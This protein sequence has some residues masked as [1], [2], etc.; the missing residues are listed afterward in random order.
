MFSFPSALS[1][2]FQVLDDD[3]Q[4]PGAGSSRVVLLPEAPT[5]SSVISIEV[6]SSDTVA[7]IP[8]HVLPLTYDEFEARYPNVDLDDLFPVR[9]LDPAGG[10]QCYNVITNYF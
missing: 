3:P 5:T 9:P 4:S 10:K 6:S 8:F 2:D 1:I 7:P